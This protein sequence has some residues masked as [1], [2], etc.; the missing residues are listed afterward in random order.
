MKHWLILT[1]E[2]GETCCCPSCLLGTVA[3]E[4]VSAELAEA[5]AE[6]MVLCEDLRGAVKRAIRVLE[7]APRPKVSGTDADN[8]EDEEVV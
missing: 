1:R 3:N 7:D 5:I 2:E 4:D 6:L 8:D